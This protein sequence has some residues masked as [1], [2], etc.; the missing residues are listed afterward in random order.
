MLCW[1]V[2]TA[3]KTEVFFVG[4]WCFPLPPKLFPCSFLH[5]HLPFLSPGL[6]D[7]VIYGFLRSYGLWNHTMKA[8]CCRSLQVSKHSLTSVVERIDVYVAATCCYQVYKL[9][10]D[11]AWFCLPNH[12][13][14]LPPFRISWVLLPYKFHATVAYFRKLLK[15]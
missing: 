9:V 5:Y 7:H 8:K 3:A 15:Q 14:K 10:C 4:F 1:E 12:L 2:W 6:F 11:A 13:R